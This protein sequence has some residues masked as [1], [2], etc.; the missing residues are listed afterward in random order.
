MFIDHTAFHHLQSECEL[1]FSPLRNLR[2]S[3]LCSLVTL[4]GPG[5]KDLVKEMGWEIL[6]S[7]LRA[8]PK[9]QVTAI[10]PVDMPGI[11]CR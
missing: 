6:S 7:L 2:P 3:P 1:Q 11:T 8:I 9:Y 10:F 4:L 5:G